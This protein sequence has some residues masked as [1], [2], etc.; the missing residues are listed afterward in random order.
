MADTILL[1]DAAIL[2]D[3][4]EAELTAWLVA[5]GANVSAGEPI[6]EISGSKAT[7]EVTAPVAGRLRRLVDTGAVLA[8]GQA[9]AAI[10][11]A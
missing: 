4:D 7:V 2:G 1:L 10:E 8:A 5:A 3:D 11:H 6:A 9:Y